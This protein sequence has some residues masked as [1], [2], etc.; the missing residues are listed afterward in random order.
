MNMLTQVTVP[1]S[2]LRTEKGRVSRPA[3]AILALATAGL[4][5][6]STPMDRFGPQAP[7]LPGPAAVA[8]IA[9]DTNRDAARAG[10]PPEYVQ[11]GYNLNFENCSAYFDALIKLQNQTRYTGDIVNAGG[12]AVSAMVGLRKNAEDAANSLVRIA[13]GSSFLGTVLSSFDERALMTPY[14][15]ETK[16]LILDGL[17]QFEA[18]AQPISATT[19]SQATMLVQRHAELCTYSGITRAAKQ[20]L[21]RARPQPD[22]EAAPSKLTVQDAETVTRISFALLMGTNRLNERQLALLHYYLNGKPTAFKDTE[23]A[24]ALLAEL[25]DGVAKLL[26]N[27]DGTLKD[28]AK[29]PNM[30]AIKDDLSSIFL[31]NK[32]MAELIEPI[33]KEFA[34]AAVADA[35]AGGAAPIKPAPPRTARTAPQAAPARPAPFIRF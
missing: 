2:A 21:T 28:P 1:V 20:A 25:P 14:P 29:V 34:P 35:E 24:E 17:S 6:C 11:Y 7:M 19:Y 26:R 3:I 32:S 27:A 12:T 23:K 8:K 31:A 5:G 30:M 10:S 9:E 18:R 33:S 22:E 13:A 15:T 16:T 4:A